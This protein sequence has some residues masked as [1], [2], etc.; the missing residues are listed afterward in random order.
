MTLINPSIRPANGVF[1]PAVATNTYVVPTPAVIFP[2]DLL[3]MAAVMPYNGATQ[4]SIS[5]TP[6]GWSQLYQDTCLPTS[7]PSQGAFTVYAA[8]KLASS[9]EPASYT[10]T[11]NVSD[12][13]LCVMVAVR[14]AAAIDPTTSQSG[15]G[16]PKLVNAS[17]VKS[18]AFTSPTLTPDN[19]NAW[20]LVPNGAFVMGIFGAFYGNAP[21]VDIQAQGGYARYGFF[22]N[23]NNGTYMAITGLAQGSKAALNARA[24]STIA[25]STASAIVPFIPTWLPYQAVVTLNPSA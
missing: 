10:W 25:E 12:R 1:A 3:I 17:N 4:P 8:R 18:T 15:P 22:A 24:A 19:D 16:S 9:A 6:S 2:G 7:D 20:P 21:G 5:A 23:G 14:D 11:A 13:P